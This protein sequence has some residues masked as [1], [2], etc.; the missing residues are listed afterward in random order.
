M[1]SKTTTHLKWD[2]LLNYFPLQEK[3]PSK[4]NLNKCIMRF[5]GLMFYN[6][7]NM[8]KMNKIIRMIFYENTN[9]YNQLI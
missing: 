5:P 2:N 8:D 6:Y 9:S 1:C 7:V 3:S 4:L